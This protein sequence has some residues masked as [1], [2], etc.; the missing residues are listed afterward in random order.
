MKDCLFL[1]CKKT[2]FL[3][4]TCLLFFMSCGS[5]QKKIEQ[6]NRIELEFLNYYRNEISKDKEILLLDTP[7]DYN[8]QECLLKVTI[9][10]EYALF[11]KDD[12]VD[13]FNSALWNEKEIVDVKLISKADLPNIMIFKSWSN[14]RKNVGKGY[15]IFSHPIVSKDLKYILFFAAYY[16]GDKCGYD[17]LALYEKTETGW[18]LVKKY[19]DGVS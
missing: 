5:E 4:I 16:C 6:K 10:K 18:K 12:F 11:D 14:F 9:E 8:L 19:C 17:S 3:S 15:H 1:R 13:K 7:S 2:I